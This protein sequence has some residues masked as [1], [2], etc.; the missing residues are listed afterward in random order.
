[1]IRLANTD[2]SSQ[3]LLV[4][5]EKPSVM[6][7]IAKALGG[8]TKHDDHYESETHV[9]AAASGHLLEQQMPRK[10]WG[11]AA[12]PIIPELIP[13]TPK[14]SQ[15]K[16]LTHLVTLLSRPDIVGVINACDAGRE[17]ELI[18]RE[19]IEH[20]ECSKPL[21][22]LWLQ[23][24]TGEGIRRAFQNIRPNASVEGLAAAGK[25][26]TIADWLIGI[27]ITRALTALISAGGGFHKTPAGRVQTPTLAMI[28]ERE[29]SVLAFIPQPYWEAVATI[30]LGQGTAVEAK[31]RAD[32]IAAAGDEGTR[33]GSAARAI[34]ISTKTTGRPAAVAMKHRLETEAPPMLFKLNDLLADASNR[35]G[36]PGDMTLKIAQSLYAEKKVISYPRT[37]YQHLRP[38]DDIE[39][40]RDQLAHIA[41]TMPDVAEAAR[42]AI[43]LGID[44]GNKRVF[45]SSKVGDHTAI[46]PIRPDGPMPMLSDTEQKIFD[47]I[48]RR[49]VGAF[50]PRSETEVV[51]L[52]FTV[53]GETFQAVRKSL[54]VP[55]WQMVDGKTAEPA[56]ATGHG[57]SNPEARVVSVE[58]EAKQTTPPGRYTDGTLLKAMEKAGKLVENE[59]ARKSMSGRG[60]GTAATR[61]E[62]LKKLISDGYVTRQ[63]R[64]LSAT[65]KAMALVQLIERLR[66]D[67]LASPEMTGEW[68]AKLQA[69]EDDAVAADVFLAEVR[70]LAVDLVE[71]VKASP[72]DLVLQELPQITLPGTGEPLVERL[73]DYSTADGRL[74]ISKVQFGRH[75]AIHELQQLLRDGVIGELDGF[76]SAKKRKP[77]SGCLRWLPAEER[78]EMFFDSLKSDLSADH[79][80]IGTCPCCGGA[81]RERPAGYVCDGAVGEEAIC[82][83]TLKRLWCG[84][85]ITPVE[86]GQL[87]RDKR[88]DLLTGF[89][90]KSGRPFKAHIVISDEGRVGFEFPAKK[91]RQART[92]TRSKNGGN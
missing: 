81:V 76:Y 53:E 6:I 86:A 92:N 82:Q 90:G 12:L 52:T 68:E 65:P 13:L 48:V 45:D 35:Y 29:R 37:E 91:G 1:M 69:I 41:A 64:Q 72:T 21:N 22:R 33:I 14:A 84:R 73:L 50:L 17:G 38:E 30:D 11:F 62:I 58:V 67:V 2:T 4:I 7:D 40:V 28:V 51:T 8:F 27:N 85:T 71:T 3:K 75:L 55:G 25:C 46:I 80:T 16:R 74:R 79:P 5:A 47:L 77:Y 49:F 63:G 66:L 26:R 23:S 43:N 54:L 32:G 59:E 24:M 87:L 39:N 60:L 18:F 19:I 15:Q 56:M 89:R 31:W 61:T 34:D 88:T 70:R 42:Q 83:L 36:F 20:A 57:L 44:P 10:K 9:V 78:C